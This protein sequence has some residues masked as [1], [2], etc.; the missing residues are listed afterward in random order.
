MKA[1]TRELPAGNVK[2]TREDWL[3]AALDVMVSDGVEQVKVLTLGERLGVSRSSFYWY[4]KDRQDL[5][6]AL[7][8][9]WQQTNT[10]AI[11]AQAG[12]NADTITRSVCNV[13]RCFVNPRLFDNRLE[14]A[15]RD[16]SRR[17]REVRE[18]LAQSDEMRLK[19]LAQMF[20]RHDYEQVEAITRARSLYYMQI[21]YNDAD[22]HES[23]D[24]RLAVVHLYVQ[25]FTGREP[26]RNEIDEFAAYAR[27]VETGA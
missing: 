15:I 27:A 21:G 18:F 8:T 20:S 23:L 13:F 10:A 11:V 25:V 12:I 2:V 5:L 16:W 17:S 26:R 24:E 4:F 1:A 22:L 6:D 7:L 14:F 9:H 3:D 19:A